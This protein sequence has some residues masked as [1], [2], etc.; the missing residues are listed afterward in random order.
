MSYKLIVMSY[1]LIVTD[2][3]STFHF[4]LSTF[5]APQGGQHGDDLLLTAHHLAEECGV[6]LGADMECLADG[7]VVTQVDDLCAFQQNVGEHQDHGVQALLLGGSGHQLEEF[8]LALQQVGAIHTGDLRNCQR[9]TCDVEF[10]V[11]GE[12]DLFGGLLFHRGGENFSAQILQRNS[13]QTG[14]TLGG[15]NVPLGAG[16][17]L[18]HNR[19]RQNGGGHHAGHVGA[20]QQAP[21]LEHGRHKCGSKKKI[22]LASGG[23]ENANVRRNCRYAHKNS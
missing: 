6:I 1:E 5:L 18:E 22:I 20:G 2:S 13:G 21:L 17:G 12:E 8:V 3:L 19:V 23:K 4:P 14:H 9:M 16:G 15:P 11:V 7:V 10:L